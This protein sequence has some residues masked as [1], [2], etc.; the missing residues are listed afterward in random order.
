MQHKRRRFNNSINAGSM[1][2]I[3][4]LLLIF[5]LITTTIVTDKGIL[6]RLPPMYKGPVPPI[7]KRNVIDIKLNAE[8]AL[9]FEQQPLAIDQLKARLKLY[10]LNK[11]KLPDRPVSP[12]KAVVSLQN[13]RGTAYEKYLEVYDQIQ[14]GYRELWEEA[15]AFQFQKNFGALSPELQKQIKGQIPQ[16]ISE[17]EPTDYFLE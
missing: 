3:A 1:A 5:F 10:I 17:A 6:I 9:L 13:D 8:G 7:H 4:F 16:V 11:D 14:A 15:A 12:G 2:D